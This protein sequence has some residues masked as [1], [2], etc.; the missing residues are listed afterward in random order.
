MDAEE[1]REE[2][3]FVVTRTQQLLT[4][5][6]KR[7]AD[8]ANWEC[9]APRIEAVPQ[10]KHYPGCKNDYVVSTLGDLLEYEYFEETQRNSIL[11]RPDMY[12]LLQV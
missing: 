11:T 9:P 7:F 2:Y 4:D 5:T 12:V 6:F 10:Y 1:E 8:N 3:E